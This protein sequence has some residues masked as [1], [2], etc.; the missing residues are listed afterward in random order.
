MQLRIMAKS[1]GLFYCGRGLFLV[2]WTAA[3][4]DKRRM[5]LCPADCAAH[6]LAANSCF[7]NRE[8]APNSRINMPISELRDAFPSAAY[9]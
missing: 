3:P 1:C 8:T 5:D 9:V 4:I 2:D 7:S 6:V